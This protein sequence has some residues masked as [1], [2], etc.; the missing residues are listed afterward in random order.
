MDAP[1]GRPAQPPDHGRIFAVPEMGGLHHNH[2][3]EACVRFG[4]SWIFGKHRLE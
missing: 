2:E 1:D 4:V 3:T